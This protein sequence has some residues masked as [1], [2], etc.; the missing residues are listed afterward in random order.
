MTAPFAWL[1]PVSESIARIGAGS[2]VC[3]KEPL[4]SSIATSSIGLPK[5]KMSFI[6]T[7]W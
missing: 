4:S 5:P 2:W 1:R 7:G 3:T 6:P